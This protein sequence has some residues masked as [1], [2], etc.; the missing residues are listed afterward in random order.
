L[1]L[2]LPVALTCG[3]AAINF[4][5]HEIGG[6]AICSIGADR[7]SELRA[8]AEARDIMVGIMSQIG[9]PMNFD[10]RAAPAVPNAEALV[11]SIAGREVRVIL[12][13]PGWMDDLRK[14]LGTNWS[15]VSFLAHEIGHHLAGHL[16]PRYANHAAELEA[17][18]FSGFI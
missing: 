7:G 12:Y 11:E 8:S 5:E 15:S 1:L 3:P 13:N 4:R 2:L 17:D 16:D 14:T 18:K 6:R 10:V 9:L